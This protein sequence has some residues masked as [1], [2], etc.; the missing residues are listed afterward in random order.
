MRNRCISYFSVDVKRPWPRKPMGER[1]YLSR[2]NKNPSWQ[3]G[4]PVRMGI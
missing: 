2:I 1:I 3:E 4:L